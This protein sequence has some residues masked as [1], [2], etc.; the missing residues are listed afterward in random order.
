MSRKQK[1]KQRK[2][3]LAHGVYA[4]DLF[5]PGE[6]TAEF[7]LLLE[8][9][10]R[11]LNPH[12]TLDNETVF[13]I[14]NLQWRKRRVQRYVQIKLLQT[15]LALKIEATGRQSARGISRALDATCE[16]D[17]TSPN[18]RFQSAISTV[19]NVYKYL[20]KRKGAKALA[21]HVQA[22]QSEIEN[23]LREMAVAKK[24]SDVADVLT[25]LQW[26][27]KVEAE[28]DAEVDRKIKRLVM[29]NEYYRLYAQQ[30]PKLIE[31]KSITQSPS[32]QVTGKTTK[33]YLKSTPKNANDNDDDDNWDNDNNNDNNN[34]NPDDY[35][36]E[37]EYD[38]AMKEKKKRQR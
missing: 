31:H 33:H 27:C 7:D 6:N 37:W 1:V 29:L 17:T 25:I 30:P 5:L 38:E 20:N 8:E 19:Q 15:P 16:K 10:R 34:I 2:N 11:D 26:A 4:S 36:H 28:L 22:L 14:A 21:K 35:D 3:A 32:T 13:E 24:Q 9:V 23:L 12:G 18:D